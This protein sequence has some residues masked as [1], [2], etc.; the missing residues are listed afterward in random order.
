[1]HREEMDYDAYDRYLEDPY[2]I[3][4]E[5]RYK[6]YLNC[7]DDGTGIDI[8]TGQPLKTFEEWLDD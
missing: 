1:M 2:L 8:T 7:A 5:A 4:L 3:P 6:N